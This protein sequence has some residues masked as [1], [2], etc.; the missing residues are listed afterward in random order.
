[1]T[2]GVKSS[3]PI[4][5]TVP[6]LARVQFLGEKLW[7]ALVQ[8]R[9]QSGNLIAQDGVVFG[10]RVSDHERVKHAKS[11]DEQERCSE[12]K[13][14]NKPGGD[15]AGLTPRPHSPRPPRPGSS[16]ISEDEGDDENETSKR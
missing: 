1:M 16:R 15:G 10:E 12:R 14:Q 7:A 2:F 3:D 8:V 13:K 5:S 6:R 9:A 4:R 11:Q